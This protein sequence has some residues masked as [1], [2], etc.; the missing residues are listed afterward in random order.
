MRIT[1][2]RVTRCALC[3]DARGQG[4]AKALRTL[5]QMIFRIKMKGIAR[6]R[7]GG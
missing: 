6:R 1:S 2:E 4:P 7:E 5:A 3:G